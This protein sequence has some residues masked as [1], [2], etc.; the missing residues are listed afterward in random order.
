MRSTIYVTRD[1]NPGMY[2]IL[3]R[4]LE[5]DHK[6]CSDDMVLRPRQIIRYETG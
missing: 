4:F 3:Y 5:R 2:R 6:S 1:I